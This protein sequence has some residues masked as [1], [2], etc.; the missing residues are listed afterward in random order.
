MDHQQAV[1]QPE[2][3]EEEA[4][5][6]AYQRSNTIPIASAQTD[7]PQTMS[8]LDGRDTLG[9][10]PMGADLHHTSHSTSLATLQPY[11]QS[12][13]FAG[14]SHVQE[15]D[16]PE[17]V[18]R[19]LAEADFRHTATRWE[20][21]EKANALS[22]MP[23]PQAITASH[24]DFAT[25]E[26]VTGYSGFYGRISLPVDSRQVPNHYPTLNNSSSVYGLG[27]NVWHSQHIPQTAIY[28]HILE[29]RAQCHRHP[30]ITFP[31]AQNYD[32]SLPYHATYG[33][34]PAIGLMPLTTSHHNTMIP[35]L[36]TN[37]Q[38]TY[39]SFLDAPTE[40]GHT[41]QLLPAQGVRSVPV[42][43]SELP[44]YTVINP[45]Y[46]TTAPSAGPS[47]NRDTNIPADRSLSTIMS[48]FPS[49]PA[50][51][52]SA[53]TYC[54]AP[55]TT[56]SPIPSQTMIVPAKNCERQVTLIKRKSCVSDSA[57]DSRTG[58]SYALDNIYFHTNPEA[59]RQRKKA[60]PKRRKVIK[61][62]SWSCF[63]CRLS[64]RRCEFSINGLCLRFF[65]YVDLYRYTPNDVV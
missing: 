36:S 46:D 63:G 51:D 22:A 40:P 47:W 21:L 18:Q 2:Q 58:P 30:N 41:Q 50:V 3:Q 54:D 27:P 11:Q 32:L 49:F 20:I 6:W 55:S 14:D 4:T 52:Q 61:K 65:R 5:E 15:S 53:T 43:S 25:N 44:M 38:E 24:S 35:V 1:A 26:I 37:D 12:A 13:G 57:S 48:K 31:N 59:D 45:V 8:L 34:Q 29:D 7:I 10:F 60:Q 23:H 33:Q 62:A 17:A 56:I 9:S 39:G 42:N 28:P 19:E 64:K 16:L